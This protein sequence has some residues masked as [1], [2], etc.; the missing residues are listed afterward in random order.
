MRHFFVSFML[1]LLVVTGLIGAAITTSG[2]NKCNVVMPV[3]VKTESIVADAAFALAQV[4]SIVDTVPMPENV[5]GPLRDA[6]AKA[7]AGLKAA[8]SVLVACIEMCKAPDLKTVFA[9]FNSAWADV[10]SLLTLFGKS[11]KGVEFRAGASLAPAQ[12]GELLIAD[13]I[14]FSFR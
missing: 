7:G 13:P 14:A 6:L 12:P 4:Q 2:C 11:G 10:R 1:G 3:L 8:N 5:K 9:E